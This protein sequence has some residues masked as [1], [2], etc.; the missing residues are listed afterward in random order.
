M[1]WYSSS[2][3]GT[4]P[5]GCSTVML[6]G[7]DVMISNLVGPPSPIVVTDPSPGMLMRLASGRSV[8]PM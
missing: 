1:R 2:W 6:I 5:P 4:E 3:R 7:N 8:D